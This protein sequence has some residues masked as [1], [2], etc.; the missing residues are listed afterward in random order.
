M[1]EVHASWADGSQPPPP[2][3]SARLQGPL[4]PPPQPAP[5]SNKPSALT[6]EVLSAF[7][8]AAL[9][10]EEDEDPDDLG[11]LAPPY[12][13]DTERRTVKRGGK[14][15]RNQADP[16]DELRAALTADRR[17]RTWTMREHIK[18]ARNVA[19]KN[20]IPIEGVNLWEL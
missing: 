3:A 17:F 2:P 13:P 19:E 4:P 1:S 9:E 7:E 8:Q 14:R 16:T 10:R 6:G 12:N 20:N 5:S 11:P 18:W 15:Q